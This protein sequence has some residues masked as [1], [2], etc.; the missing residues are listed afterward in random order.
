M[1]RVKTTEALDAVLVPPVMARP[2]VTVNMASFI[3]PPL[4]AVATTKMGKALPF[5]KE[6]EM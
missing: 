3:C 1:A 6:V 5:A 4:G 2:P